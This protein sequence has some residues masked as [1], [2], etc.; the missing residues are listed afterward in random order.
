MSKAATSIFAY[1]LDSISYT[2]FGGSYTLTWGNYRGDR[3]GIY[4]YNNTADSGYVDVDWFT[5]VYAGPK[6][7]Q[8][9]SHQN[10]PSKNAGQEFLLTSSNKTLHMSIPA[11]ALSSGAMATLT[12]YSMQGRAVWSRTVLAA[13]IMQVKTNGLACGMYMGR[14]TVGNHAFASRIL[15]V[16]E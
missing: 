8:V 5:Y 15:T 14:L 11:S 10:V 6:S 3:L 16:R 7:T 13:A 9:Q 12:L 4:N 1:S 2:T